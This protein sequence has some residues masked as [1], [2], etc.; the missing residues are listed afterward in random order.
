[1]KRSVL[2][3]CAILGLA[4]AALAPATARA[5]R[6]PKPVPAA[7]VDGLSAQDREMLALANEF[8]RRCTDTL[9]RWIA[10]KEV[11]QDQLFS[12][13]YY[14]VPNTDPPKFTTDWDRLS[15]RDILGVEESILARSP[16]I[17]FTVMVDRYGYLPTHNQRYSLPLTGNMA[18]DLVNNR[19][20]RIFNDRTGL[21]AA[22][23]EA[24]FLIQRYQRDT[25]ETMVDLSV[26]VFVRGVHWGAVRIG[27]RAVDS[28]GE[29]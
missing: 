5:Q 11:T 26:P 17:I 27:F 9:E 23:N 25:G 21:A 10:S 2:E 12:F 4:L 8:A 16:T 7:V 15:D 6:A 28:K 24:A 29:L 19:T 1:M 13:L 3:V 14:P 20:K 18:S 22:Q